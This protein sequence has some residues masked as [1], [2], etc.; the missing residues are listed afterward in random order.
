MC[1]CDDSYQL[2]EQ[3]DVVDAEQVFTAGYVRR[4]G[5]QGWGYTEKER[6]VAGMGDSCKR[7]E[8]AYIYIQERER[9]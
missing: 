7:R 9:E 6:S 8:S 2:N 5:G 4:T 3:D 1:R